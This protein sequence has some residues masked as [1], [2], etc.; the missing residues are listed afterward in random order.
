MIKNTEDANKYYAIINEYIDGY[1]DKWKIDAKKLKK[2]LLNNNKLIHFLEK[3]G[4]N[5]I[6]NIKL[7]INDVIDDRIS[8]EKD[9]VMTLE[10]FKINESYI[11][12]SIA[13]CIYFG[14]DKSSIQHE[15]ILADQFDVSLGHINIINSE[16]HIF[17]VEENQY[18]IFLKEEIEIIKEN[19]KEFFLNK[20]KTKKFIMDD[21]LDI[22]IKII[23]F[24]D[25]DKF[26][27]TFLANTE[28]KEIISKI[29]KLETVDN[30]DCFI[31]KKRG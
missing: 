31:G 9:K 21:S 23:D 6:S 16:K 12:S 25:E 15:K 3:K 11:F 28:I 29:L 26:K 10:S 30:T 27:N 5:N 17:S 8:I 18:I 24:I 2:Y 20:L 19:L 4:L 7:V 13:E 1:L 14:I 22:K